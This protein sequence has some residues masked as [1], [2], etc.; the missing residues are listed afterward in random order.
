ME[1]DGSM[2]WKIEVDVFR[3]VEDIGGRVPRDGRYGWTCPAEWE[4]EV[5]VFR[6]VEDRG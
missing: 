3:G 4:T 2:R 6:G 1:A 5:D